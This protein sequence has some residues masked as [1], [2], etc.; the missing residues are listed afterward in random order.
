MQKM[1]CFIPISNYCRV[2]IFLQK[3]EKFIRFNPVMT[4]QV[5]LSFLLLFF[6]VQRKK[7]RVW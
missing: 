7:K 4:Y 5:R 2:L 3:V 6:F 1:D